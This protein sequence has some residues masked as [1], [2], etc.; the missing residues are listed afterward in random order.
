MQIVCTELDRIIWDIVRRKIITIWRI[1]LSRIELLIDNIVDHLASAIFEECTHKIKEID[2]IYTINV[3]LTTFR[4]YIYQISTAKS[5]VMRTGSEGTQFQSNPGENCVISRQVW[6][7]WASTNDLTNWDAKTWLVP[8][9]ENWSCHFLTNV[10]F[11]QRMK[12]ETCVVRLAAQ[13]DSFLCVF[14]HGICLLISQTNEKNSISK[15]A[16]FIGAMIK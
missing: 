3:A 11:D 16:I 14:L 2:C 12:S 7:W 4:F 6:K 1:N 13:R 8:L 15:I 10:E 9:P 5:S